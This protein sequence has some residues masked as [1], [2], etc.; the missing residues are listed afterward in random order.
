M[1]AINRPLFAKGGY[2]KQTPSMQKTLDMMDSGEIQAPGSTEFNIPDPVKP[3]RS[4]YEDIGILSEGSMNIGNKRAGVVSDVQDK[5]NKSSLNPEGKEQA[6]AQ[7]S[8]MVDAPSEMLMDFGLT[9]MQCDSPHF[10]DCLAQGMTAVRAGKMG[11]REMAEASKDRELKRK[12]TKAQIKKEDAQAAKFISDAFKNYSTDGISFSDMTNRMKDIRDIAKTR[13]QCDI[14]EKTCAEDASAIWVSEKRATA[15]E[16][17]A[18]EYAKGQAKAMTEAQSLVFNEARMADSVIS[19]IDQSLDIVD[20]PNV[21]F[22]TGGELVGSF[23]TFLSTLGIES[24]EGAANTEQFRVNAMTSVMDWIAQTKGAISEKEMDMFIAASPS[25][26]KTREG[27]KLIL[28]T[29]RKVAQYK[30]KE[31][32]H[33]LK[34]LGTVEGYPTVRD[35]EKS[36]LEFSEK[37]NIPLPSLKIAEEAPEIPKV[38][39]KPQ[40]YESITIDQIAEEMAGIE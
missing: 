12:L 10:S 6:S 30:Q 16:A 20:D 25:L 2:V 37:N 29:A 19:K 36:R 9:M 38:S 40:N 27:N 5:I 33:L 34:W 8:S 18:K 11:R 1:R 14:N 21:Y 35:W 39:K 13:L 23:R 3:A 7:L 26:T 15:D 22:G 4:S 24:P 28:Q 17:G 31:R 32:D